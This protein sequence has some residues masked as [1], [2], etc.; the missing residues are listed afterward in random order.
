MRVVIQRVLEASVSINSRIYNK[1][2]KGL[3]LLVAFTNN[4]ILE[5]LEYV[6]HKIINLRIFN[7]SNNKLNLSIKDL[8][9]EIL[10]ISQF[11]LYAET[12]KGNRPSFTR[13]LN[14]IEAKKLYEEFNNLLNKEITT[15]SGIFQEDMKINLI[16][17]GP[18][19]I[20]IDSKMRDF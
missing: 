6:S 4:D 9:Y 20:I 7:D 19:S 5:D 10:S 18:V 1:I 11:T 8:N 3:L 16:N 12:K 14:P 13:S 15:K 2:D 17:D